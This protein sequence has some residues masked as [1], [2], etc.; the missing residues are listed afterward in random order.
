MVVFAAWRTATLMRADRI[1]TLA[2]LLSGAAR[3][4]AEQA[5]AMRAELQEADAIFARLEASFAAA[6]ATEA[7]KAASTADRGEQR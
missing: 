2:R 5:A 3:T 7:V 1:P 4:T 6:A